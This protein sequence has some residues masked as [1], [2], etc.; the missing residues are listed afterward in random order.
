MATTLSSIV[1][2]KVLEAKYVDGSFRKAEVLD[3][4]SAKKRAKAPVK[5]RYVDLRMDAWLQLADL[6][7]TDL[8]LVGNSSGGGESD[9]S[10][11]RKGARVSVEAQ[12]KYYAAEVLRVSKSRTSQT[13]VLIRRLGCSAASEEWVSLDRIRS[14]VLRSESGRCSTK[15]G[16]T[17]VVDGG[18]LKPSSVSDSGARPSE[19]DRAQSSCGKATELPRSGSAHL[20]QDALGVSSELPQDVLGPSSETV[21]TDVPNDTDADKHATGAALHDAVPVAEPGLGAECK[22]VQEPEP[23]AVDGTAC[24]AHSPEAE[25]APASKMMG[26]SDVAQECPKPVDD[27]VEETA[28][29]SIDSQAVDA[30][31]AANIEILNDQQPTDEKHSQGETNRHN[32]EKVKDMHCAKCDDTGKRG[33]FGRKGWGLVSRQ[34]RHCLERRAAVAS[35]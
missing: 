17:A 8:G 30:A 26:D 7:A 9:V 35:C 14:R 23:L 21:P 2:G 31:T 10:G 6:R 29:P 28:L 13:P 27:A 15:P 19:G 5:V 3:V 24:V 33:F 20:D 34:C 32:A 16:S 1:V 11:L 25:A 18:S 12:G 4:S 22:V